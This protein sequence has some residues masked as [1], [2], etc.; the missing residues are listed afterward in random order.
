[1]Q[2]IQ[3]RSKMIQHFE[4]SQIFD[5]LGMECEGAFNEIYCPP[6]SG[7][8]FFWI[9]KDDEEMKELEPCEQEVA[10]LLF[11]YGGATPG[12]KI[13]IDFDY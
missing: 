10:K 12:D 7:S 13:C 9:P 5:N 1:M 2:F 6:A 4:A 3:L 8:V 11:N